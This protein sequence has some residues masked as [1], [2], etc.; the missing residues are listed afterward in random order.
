LKITGV[1]L[2]VKHLNDVTGVNTW[3]RLCDKHGARVCSR[4]Q[5]AK[6]PFSYRLFYKHSDP[7]FQLLLAAHN[8]KFF[9]TI[10]VTEITPPC[11][12][13]TL[14]LTHVAADWFVLTCYS[15]LWL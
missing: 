6:L 2:H 5:L 11:M 4:L 3:R 8:E 15:T 1:V 7:S 10:S 9:I 13:I 14:S 12:S